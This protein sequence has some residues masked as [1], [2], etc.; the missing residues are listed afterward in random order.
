MRCDRTA[1]RLPLALTAAAT[2]LLLLVDSPR[3]AHAGGGQANIEQGLPLHFEDTVPQ[4]YLGREFQFVSRYERT[5][6]GEDRWLLEP[7][8]ELGIWQNTQLTIASPFLFGDADE[9]DGLGPIELDVLYNV[10]VETLDLPAFAFKAGVDFTGAAA[11]GGGDGVDPFVGILIDRTIGDTS[12][13]QKLHVNATY[14]FNGSQLDD[15]RDG[16][17]EVALGFSRR[18]GASAVFVADLVRMQEM[19][20]HD[21]VNLAEFGIRYATTPQSVFSAGVGFGVGDES[22]DVRFTL[23]FQ[24]EF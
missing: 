24:F 5:D 8:L 6:E 19:T 12:L 11:A 14:Q 18:L 21:E 3:P 9:G 4:E 10:N 20:E 17:Y 1:H 16:R 2:S 23:G 7:R 15:E 22:P 13:Y